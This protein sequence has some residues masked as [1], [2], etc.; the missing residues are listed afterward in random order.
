MKSRITGWA[1]AFTAT[2]LYCSSTGAVSLAN[3]EDM[4][5]IGTTPIT[6]EMSVTPADGPLFLFTNDFDVEDPNLLFNL[7]FSDIENIQFLS[8]PIFENVTD[9][10]YVAS[11]DSHTD[12]LLPDLGLLRDYH[13]HPQGLVGPEG[14]SFS[15]TVW[16]EPEPLAE[17]PVPAAFWLFGSGL[18]GMIGMARQKKGRAISA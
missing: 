4:G 16:A 12:V 2:A 3:G 1:L 6:F 5:V 8:T 17:I 18:L 13:L 11:A 14:G 15:M 7:R 9:S 10:E